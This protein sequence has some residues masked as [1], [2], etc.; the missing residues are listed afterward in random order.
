MLFKCKDNIFIASEDFLIKTSINNSDLIKSLLKNNNNF[1][2]LSNII[3]FKTISLLNCFKIKFYNDKKII[4]NEK[5]ILELLEFYDYMLLDDK[6]YEIEKYF[7]VNFI[8][9]K[10]INEI[11]KIIPIDSINNKKEFLK[12]KNKWNWILTI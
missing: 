11:K 7:M 8:N 1:I 4:P 10:N 3:S 12:F 9:F 6:Y 2:D 5:E